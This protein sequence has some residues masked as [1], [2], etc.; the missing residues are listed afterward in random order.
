MNYCVNTR[1]CEILT[2][3][4]CSFASIRLFGGIGFDDVDLKLVACHDKDKEDDSYDG[5][6]DDRSKYGKDQ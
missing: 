5:G 6:D 1:S 3:C 2:T 4:V